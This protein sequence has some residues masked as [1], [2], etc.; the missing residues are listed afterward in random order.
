MPI[1]KDLFLAILA[2][3]AYNRGYNAGIGNNVDGLGRTGKI[4]NATIN[5]VALPTGSVSASFYAQSYTISGAT[6]DLASLNGQTVISY[7]GT[8]QPGIDVSKAYWTGGG[9]ILDLQARQAFEFYNTVKGSTPSPIITT[10]H[11]LGGGHAGLV[12]A[13]H[14]LQGWLYDNMPFV[15]AAQRL[16]QL[17]LGPETFQGPL[18]P[19]A[20]G[21]SG[22]SAQEIASLVY[23]NGAVNAPTFSNIR[24][25]YIPNYPFGW[26][27]NILASVRPAQ[28]FQE[29]AYLLPPDTLLRRTKNN[30]LGSGMIRRS[31]SSASSSMGRNQPGTGAIP[32][33]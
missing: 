11:S 14:G 16:H 19:S 22:L 31:A 17:G 13:T 18:V 9:D 15:L 12:A 8:D 1:S 5:D 27:S 20:L 28:P 7:R 6:G 33:K 30:S 24:M 29:T 26:T 3:D 2:M 10:G 21:G 4:G 25:S 32:P 23:G